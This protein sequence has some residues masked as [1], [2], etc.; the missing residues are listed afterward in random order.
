MN[1]SIVILTLL[2]ISL[3]AKA[4]ARDFTSPMLSE[5]MMRPGDRMFSE[6]RAFRFEFRHDGNLAVVRN[7]DDYTQWESGTSGSGAQYLYFGQT[8]YGELGI[9][10]RCNQSIPQ[11]TELLLSNDRFVWCGYAGWHAVTHFNP[12]HLVMQDDGN[13][14]LWQEVHGTL[15]TFGGRE[16][17]R[18]PTIPRR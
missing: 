18:C 12:V 11:I 4:G 2:A 16:G 6:N 8:L 7:S 9:L 14:V 3:F 1:K 5:E 13:L 10:V 15:C 17:S